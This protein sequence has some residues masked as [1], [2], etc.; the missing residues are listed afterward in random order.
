MFSL[1]VI[2]QTFVT[3]LDC[4]W[5]LCLRKW[6]LCSRCFAQFWPVHLL[7]NN[8]TNFH[9][10]SLR[11]PYRLKKYRIWLMLFFLLSVIEKSPSRSYL[12]FITQ[13]RLRVKN[14]Y[15]DHIIKKITVTS[16]QPLMFQGATKENV[17]PEIGKLTAAGN[18]KL[19]IYNAC[20]KILW[21]DLTSGRVLFIPTCI[22]ISTLELN[23][24][25][26]K[27]SFFNGSLFQTK[28]LPRSNRRFAE[29][30]E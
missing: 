9:C 23:C 27:W 19:Y 1:F 24:Q 10:G 3:P 15:R 13:N 26:A 17:S 7:Q 28:S 12:S 20:L 4:Y 16:I 6:Q 11:P 2:E 25:S 21:R 22:S 30:L 8:R 5:N 29:V 14:Y 18:I